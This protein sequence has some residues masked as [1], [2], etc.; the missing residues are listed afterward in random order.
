[1]LKNW[2]ILIFMASLRVRAFL[3]LN[4][5]QNFLMKLPEDRLEVYLEVINE[6]SRRIKAAGFWGSSAVA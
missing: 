4:G 1:M 3:V 2:K 6:H 5:L